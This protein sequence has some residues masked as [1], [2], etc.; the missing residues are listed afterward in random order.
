M[1]MSKELEALRKLGMQTVYDEEGY[2]TPVDI[3]L[4]RDYDA[5]EQALTPPT[6]D[7]VCEALSE[8]FGKKVFIDKRYKLVE[9]VV[10]PGSIVAYIDKRNNLNVGSLPPYLSTL[11][12]RFYEGLANE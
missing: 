2:E 10:E 6:A 5:L 8:H 1:K 9:F 3:F 12:G 11:I 4:R 7:D